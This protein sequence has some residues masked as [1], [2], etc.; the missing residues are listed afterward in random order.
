MDMIKALIDFNDFG[1]LVMTPAEFVK[2]AKE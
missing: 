2:K 1:I